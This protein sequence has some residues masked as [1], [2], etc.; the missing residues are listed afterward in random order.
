MHRAGRIDCKG[1][2]VYAPSVFIWEGVHPTGDG[3]TAS[4]DHSELA[5]VFDAAANLMYALASRPPGPVIE[6]VDRF[7][8]HGHALGE[9]G[10]L[11]CGFP[12]AEVVAAYR[13]Y[14]RGLG[15]LTDG[16]VR[17]VTRG[18]FPE[19]PS[20]NLLLFEG[21]VDAQRPA[22][23]LLAQFRSLLWGFVPARQARLYE[24][25]FTE[26][27]AN[28][29]RHGRQ[30]R[31]AVYQ[32]SGGLSILAEDQGPGIPLH[33]LPSSLLVVGYTT[34]PGSL[35]AGFP[36]IIRVAETVT[37]AT[38]DEGTT[39]LVRLTSTPAEVR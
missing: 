30:G 24:L 12:S 7:L 13:C 21:P 38:G 15:V 22:Y 25:A 4:C 17:L 27:A 23:A 16:R 36:T 28:T 3:D 14:A 20:R 6:Q 33:V 34:V 26:L 35:G 2:P 37:I 11:V 32:D 8:L 18:T 10:S 39:V 9:Y 5:A 19:L 31:M 29:L 1:A